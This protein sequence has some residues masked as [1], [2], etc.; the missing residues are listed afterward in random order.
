MIKS[1]EGISL[2][3][4]VLSI[5]VML[6]ILTTIVISANNIIENTR[7][8][9]I[10]REMS[11]VQSS[12]ET[13]IARNT[14]KT[15]S[16]NM[17]DLTIADLAPGAV[18]QFNSEYILDGKVT[19][20]VIDLSEIDVEDVNY[21]NGQQGTNDRYLVSLRTGKVYYEKGF[22]IGGETYYTVTP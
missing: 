14:E 19:L 6:L 10:F 1:E 15:S 2:V 3:T 12:W 7:K 11:L 4:V 18:S 13:Y 17:V 8:K 20:A 21:G 5:L 22:V 9:Q 16:L